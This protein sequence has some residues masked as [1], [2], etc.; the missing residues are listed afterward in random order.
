MIKKTKLK[1]RSNKKNQDLQYLNKKTPLWKPLLFLSSS[2][3][4]IIAL[5]VIP[6]IITA[7]YSGTVPGKHKASDSYFGTKSFENVFQDFY[8]KNAIQNSILFAILV[9]PITVLIS[10]TISGIIST[11]FNKK[12]QS[13]AQTLFFLP[14]ITNALSISLAFAY[15][16]DTQTGFINNAFGLNI[17]WLDDQ[18]S[19]SF[20]AMFVIL[21]KGVWTGIAFQ[22]LIF[23]NAMMSVDKDKY[24]AAAI[25]G[26]SRITM[27]FKITLPSIKKS[28]GFIIAVGLIG[29]IKVFPLALFD[30]NVNAAKNNGGMTLMMYVYQNIHDGHY[31][32]AS[33]AVI[34]L[35]LIS[36]ALSLTINNSY[37]L[38][39]NLIEKI[40]AKIE[41]NKIEY[42][43]LM[44]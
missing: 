1:I 38:T 41:K 15:L 29:S 30:N 4:F 44:K 24:K 8:F 14:Y 9:I 20:N 31:Y 12:L 6:F 33:A 36:I 10:L 42:S 35:V 5:M 27:F 26:A 21:I 28:V 23:T 18:S 2:L 3:I 17:A 22:I 7:T 11:L 16:F 13:S 43:I 40:G 37:K 19:N 32:I 25:D 39:I 34:I